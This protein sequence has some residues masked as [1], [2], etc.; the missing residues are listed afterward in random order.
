MRHLLRTPSLQC[1]GRVRPEGRRV[2]HSATRPRFHACEARM[3]R[4]LACGE[5]I[6]RVSLWQSV[7]AL[8]G[9]VHAAPQH[10]EAQSIRRPDARVDPRLLDAPSARGGQERAHDLDLPAG[11]RQARRL[12]RRPRHAADP[13]G[14]PA[15]ASRGV[16]RGARRARQ[17]PRHDQHPVP[18]AA[19]L[20]GLAGR[21]R[22]DRAQLH[23]AHAG[24]VRA[25]RSAAASS[26]R[27]ARAISTCP[28]TSPSSR[29]R[30]P[31]AAGAARSSPAT[32]RPGR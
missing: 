20:L 25:P 11:A 14:H 23:G 17:R 16:L 9:P 22:R 7:S 5:G 15:R 4:I 21:G 29:L 18:R 3:P 32:R 27:C 31:R 13:R 10:Q 8:R 26:P 6:R 19:A 12:S 30:S 24:A 1:P 2:C 28:S